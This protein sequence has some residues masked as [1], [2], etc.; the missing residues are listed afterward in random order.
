MGNSDFVH[1][2]IAS[3]YKNFST[4]MIDMH[5]CSIAHCAA[6]R[7]NTQCE[8]ISQKYGEK[9]STYMQESNKAFS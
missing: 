4:M 1:R 9:I 3:G 6:Y 5:V 7:I 8:K 2:F